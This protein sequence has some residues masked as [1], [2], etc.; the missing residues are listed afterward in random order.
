MK[1]IVFASAFALL[2]VLVFAQTEETGWHLKDPAAD[3]VNGTGVEKVYQSLAKGKE[4][5]TVVVAIID[6]GVD[7]Y[8]E[9][10]VDNIWVNTD[11]VAGNNIDDDQN[12]YVD[13]MHGWNFLGAPDGTNINAE[14]LELTRLYAKY[15]DYFEGKDVASLNKRDKKLYE[16]YKEYERIIEK[17]RAKA[18]MA[19]GSMEQNE[20]MLIDAIHAFKKKYPETKL[21]P[22]FMTSF[23]PGDDPQMQVVQ[24]IFQQIGNFGMEVESIE[25]IEKEIEVG[26]AE[27]KND[28]QNKLEYGY[29]PD[30]DARAI[31]GDNYADSYETGYGNN[32]VIGEF[33]FHGTHVAGIVGATR[34]NDIGVKGIADNVQLMVLRTVP[35]GDERDK[36]VANAIRY[37]VDN[38]ASVVNMS[39]GKGQSWDKRAVDKAVKHAMKNDVLLVHAA[40]NEAENNDEI[41]HYPTP[42]FEKKGLFG[43]K[44]ADN[45]IEVGALSPEQG[46]GAPASFSNYGAKEVDIFAPGVQINSTGPDN[47][48]RPASGTSMASPVVAG[49]AAMIRSYF[50]T[51]TAKQVKSIL[52]ESVIAVDYK[53]RKPGTSEL[54][55]MSDLCNT[56]GMVSAERAFEL[57]SKTKGKKKVSK[58]MQSSS[59]G[60]KTISS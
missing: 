14:T 50:P 13:D 24:Q 53:V 6:S 40:G 21:T 60:S 3:G 38:G 17:E 46:E 12:G 32:D 29:N 4:S 2:T 25:Q 56:G 59:E 58:T 52:K 57:A 33:N 9:D 30:F 49:V 5:Q 41:A 19:L 34:D 54:V 48:Y 31:I 20:A 23:D 10:L 26:Y 55:P 45:W 27:A 16:T 39:F 36:D 22:D 51:L 47:T 28:F 7:M 18:E 8:H 37:A 43:K 42:T 35:D 1:R 44:Y 11:E 15:R